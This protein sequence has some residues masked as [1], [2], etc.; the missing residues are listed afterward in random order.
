MNPSYNKLRCVRCESQGDTKPYIHTAGK[1]IGKKK[2]GWQVTSTYHTGICEVPVCPNCTKLFSRWKKNKRL[3]YRLFA[4]SFI[5]TCLFGTIIFV[6][7]LTV[8]LM[9]DDPD[10]NASFTLENTLPIIILVIVSVILGI[11]T[12]A[13]NLL[14]SNPNI[15]IRFGRDMVV[16]TPKNTERL[17]TLAGWNRIITQEQI[18]AE[19]L[20]LKAEKLSLSRNFIEALDFYDKALDLFPEYLEAFYDKVAA[21][22][23]LKRYN[24]ALEVN[25]K[26]LEFY[27]EHRILKQRKDAIL[28]LIAKNKEKSRLG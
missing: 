17:W 2:I 23:K 27:P 19:K 6:I 28:R 1:L 25:N 20:H 26:A 4:I 5:A 7:I 16:I 21:L 24:E 18:E 8:P 10:T 3:M 9:D 22:I 11:Y 15:Y 13:M 14:D 12:S